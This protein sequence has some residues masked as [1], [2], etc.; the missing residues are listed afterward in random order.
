MAP[1]VLSS[2]GMN[3]PIAASPPIQAIDLFCGAGGLTYGL[4]KAEIKVLA[5]VDVDP[6][7]KFPYEE[8][9]GTPFCLRDVSQLTGQMLNNLFTD[10]TVRLLAGCAPCQ[11]FSNYSNGRNAQLSSKWGLL[12]EFGRIIN[13]LRPELV[14][15]E[16]VPQIEKHAPFRDFVQIL[17]RNNYHVVW[18]VVDCAQFG[19]PQRRKRLV[20]LASH[21]GEIE[22]LRPTHPDPSKWITVKRAIGGLSK[23]EAGVRNNAADQLHIAS[24]LSDKNLSR[25]RKSSPG[26]TWSEWPEALRAECHQRESGQSFK[27]VYGRMVW[28]QPSPTMTT[29]CF[30]FGNGRFGHPEQD[31]AISLREAAILQSFPHRYTFCPEDQT[32]EFRTIG[33]M[34]GN[35]VPPALGHAIGKAFASHVFNVGRNARRACV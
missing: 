21:L 11:P 8:N 29:L 22:M 20:L 28:D 16:N 35:A 9:N 30:G 19:I 10:G 23:I 1:H 12:A 3:K 31:R 4:R 33:R 5:G 14:T 34:I 26:G 27:S 24:Q 2:E 18:D 25:I 7:C 13:E 32:P 17:K 15:M 6:A